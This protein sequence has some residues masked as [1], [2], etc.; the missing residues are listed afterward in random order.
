MALC[1]SEG[2][3]RLPPAATASKATPKALVVSFAIEA[4]SLIRRQ[5]ERAVR[6]LSQESV[7]RAAAGEILG[8]REVAERSGG[9]TS[10]QVRALL[11][12]QRSLGRPAN[13][14]TFVCCHCAL[15]RCRQ[16]ALRNRE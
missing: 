10:L 4:P 1:F 14:P 9:G 15:R 13:N 2:L 11:S 12:L 8:R 7:A 3:S 6:P 16:I 5:T